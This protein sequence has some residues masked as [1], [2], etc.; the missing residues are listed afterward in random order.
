MRSCISRLLGV[1]VVLVTCSMS[2][3]QSFELLVTQT[4]PGSVDITNP[5]NWGGVL[6]YTLPSA[7]GAATPGTGIGS[8]SLSDPSGL[9]HSESLGKLFVGN[10]KGNTVDTTVTRFDHVAGGGFTNP[11]NFGVTGLQG[12]HQVALSPTT[13]ELFVASFNNGIRRFT[14]PD[15]TA[16]DNGVIFSGASMR[17]VAISPDGTRLFGTVASGV[18]RQYDLVNNL[19]LTAFDL[20]PQGASSLHF[21]RLR[22]SSELYAADFGSDRVF[23]MDLAANVLSNPTFFTSNDAISLAFSPDLSEMFV[24]THQ[25]STVIRRYTFDSGTDAWLASSAGDIAV[26]SSLGDIITIAIPEPASI[27]LIGLAGVALLLRRR[28]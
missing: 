6:N 23:A 7:Q 19:E 25:T 5:A 24:S 2:L 9:V 11:N 22:G 21:L 28:K 1:V 4:P 20:G 16:T 18:I 27:G 10:R 26:G 17:G 15:A 8:A 3:A 14:T 13:G 12:I